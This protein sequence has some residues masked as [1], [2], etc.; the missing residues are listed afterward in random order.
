LHQLVG[1]FGQLNGI[2]RL[3]NFKGRHQRSK[4]IGCLKDRAF[5]SLQAIRIGNDLPGAA[6]LVDFLEGL[7]D[8]L[9]NVIRLTDSAGCI[10]RH[11]TTS[12]FG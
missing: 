8:L 4:F 11:E 9:L 12:L 10:L 5:G 6:N 3:L 2:D 7:V 1:S